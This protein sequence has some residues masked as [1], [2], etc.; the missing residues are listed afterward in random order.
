MQ[1]EPKVVKVK[2][3]IGQ[4]ECEWQTIN[5]NVRKCTRADVM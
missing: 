2:F 4:I 3:T 5:I 1:T